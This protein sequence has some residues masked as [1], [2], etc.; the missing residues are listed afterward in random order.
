MTISPLPWP[1]NPP[2]LAIPGFTLLITLFNCLEESGIL[3]ATME[4]I[5]PLSSF[6]FS[7]FTI[8]FSSS[9]IKSPFI[10]RSPINPKFVNTSTP[11]VYSLLSSFTI[12]EDVPI[13]PFN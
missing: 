11:T 3:V 7:D 9:P 6:C 2:V 13:P 4:I 8:F 10:I 1:I 5:E 12:R